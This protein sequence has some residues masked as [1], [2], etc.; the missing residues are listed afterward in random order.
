MK[1]PVTLAFYKAKG[2]LMDKAIR[3]WTKSKYS[4][5]EV[6]YSGKSYGNIP[7]E[8]MSVRSRVH[9]YNTNSWDLV[10]IDI[11][12][13]YFLEFYEKT[14]D[15]KYDWVGIFLSQIFPF[16][17]DQR[18]KFFCSEWAAEACQ[19]CEK[20]KGNRYSPG[21]VYKLAIK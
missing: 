11:D 10:H 7:G 18:K 1:K 16:N 6:I 17:T 19:L 5:V 4:H 12:I 14:K 15:Y 2:S 13:D 3:I 20:G 8:D 21:E 9:S